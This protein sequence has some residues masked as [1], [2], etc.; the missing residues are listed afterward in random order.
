M[1]KREATR[2]GEDKKE[3]VVSK[4]ARM[5]LRICVPIVTHAGTFQ[6]LQLPAKQ[7]Q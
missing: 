7:I 1:V 3:R 5:S 6:D 2:E 4:A